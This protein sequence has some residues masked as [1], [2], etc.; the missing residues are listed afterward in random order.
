MPH[1]TE[2]ARTFMAD[3]LVWDAHAGM[4]PTPDADLSH[5][6]EW[7]DA[8]VD[9]VSIN[10]CFDVLNW[11]DGIATLSA[12]RR[13]LGAMSDR[14]HIVTKVEDVRDARSSNKLAVAFDIE[15]VNALNDDPGMVSVYHDLGVRQMLLAYNLGN[16]GSGGCHDDDTGLTPFGRD[17]VAEMNRV[18]IT[19]DLSHMSRRSTFDALEISSAPPVFSHSNSRRLRDHERNIDDDQIRACA[20]AGG[21]IGIN[22][23]GIF[24]GENDISSRTFADHVCYVADLTGPEHVAI[25]LDWKPVG[26]KSGP[27]MGAFLRSRPDYWPKAQYDVSGISMFSPEQLPEV[28]AT[29]RERGWSESELKGFL[30]ENFMRVAGVSWSR[31]Q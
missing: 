11:T 23:I 26:Q 30:G 2:W 14:V 9:F 8:G 21:V 22:G 10:I 15:G 27:D 31:A 28:I 18:G 25:G 1:D 16:S 24:L 29:L 20:D 5:I 12:F 13:Q 19:V 7:S 17:V 3:S 4:F 6:T